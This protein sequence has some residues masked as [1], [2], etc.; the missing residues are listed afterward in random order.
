MTSYY[1][2]DLEKEAAKPASSVEKGIVRR[3]SPN[4]PQEGRKDDTGK[5]RLELVAPE[6]LFAL[7]TILTFG[8]EKYDARNW[9]KGMSWGRVF[10]ALMRHLWAWWGGARPTRT[11]FAFGQLDAET[12]HSH[13]WH[14]A[15]C[16]MFLVSYEQTGTGTD[17]R[18]NK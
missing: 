14:A 16:L 17:D 8:A 9:E 15:A 5:V 18:P 6:F 12:G 3:P 1:K 10:G 7:A 2:H 13:L 11:S 4:L